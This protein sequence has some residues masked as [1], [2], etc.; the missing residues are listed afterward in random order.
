MSTGDEKDWEL[1]NCSE[2]YEINYVKKLYTKPDAVETWI[3]K[4]CKTD[5]KIN[6]TTH[7]QLYAMLEAAGFTKK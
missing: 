5:G 4:E 1:F 7:A 6:N 3:V 2:Q